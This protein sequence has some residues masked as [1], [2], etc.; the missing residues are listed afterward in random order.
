MTEEEYKAAIEKYKAEHS[1]GGSLEH[2]EWKK[3]K[4]IRIENGRYIYP[5]DLKKSG[6]AGQDV[7]NMA[8]HINSVAKAAG[9]KER[10]TGTVDKRGTVW[11]NSEGKKFIDN[12]NLV[13]LG[14]PPYYTPTEE[15]KKQDATKKTVDEKTK[16]IEDEVIKYA[17]RGSEAYNNIMDNTKKIL[18][19][20]P[21]SKVEVTYDKDKDSLKLT[22]KSAYYDPELKRASKS[23]IA[24][25][26]VN[27]VSERGKSPTD[28]IKEA[29]DSIKERKNAPLPEETSKKLREDLRKD[30]LDDS[31]IT[32]IFNKAY[33]KWQKETENTENPTKARLVQMIIKDGATASANKKNSQKKIQHSYTDSKSFYSAVYDYKQAHKR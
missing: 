15:Q 8:S 9:S 21:E 16:A 4:Y 11:T 20:D 27:N 6:A 18:S 24:I 2:G 23:T 13:A 14:K 33:E 5:E 31:E 22:N 32:S 26:V 10:I 12:L 25:A 29:A 28:A 7:A 30:G 1:A 19:E 17:K 3:H